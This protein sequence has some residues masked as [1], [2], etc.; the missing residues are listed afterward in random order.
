MRTTEVNC[1][2]VGEKCLAIDEYARKLMTTY[3]V[4]QVPY[5]KDAEHVKK[6][7]KDDLGWNIQVDTDIRRY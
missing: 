7:L 1:N 4:R 5:S 2:S 3:A 6:H